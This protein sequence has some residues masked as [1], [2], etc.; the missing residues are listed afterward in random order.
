[1]SKILLDQTQIKTAGDPYLEP[2]DDIEILEKRYGHLTPTEAAIEYCDDTM[3]CNYYVN[4]KC[5]DGGCHQFKQFIIDCGI[6]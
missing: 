1:M 4:N 5:V 6:V 2:M 3:G